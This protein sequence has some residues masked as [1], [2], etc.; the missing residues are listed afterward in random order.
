MKKLKIFVMGRD[1]KG[2][3]RKFLYNLVK[4]EANGK[5][6]HSTP[7]NELFLSP[8][9]LGCRVESKICH[10]IH[11]SPLKYFCGAYPKRFVVLSSLV[12]PKVGESLSKFKTAVHKVGNTDPFN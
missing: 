10:F 2:N 6:S 7:L 11:P 3:I 9:K 1:G 8:S 4:E 5:I 12:E